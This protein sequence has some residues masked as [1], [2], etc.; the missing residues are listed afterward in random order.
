MLYLKPAEAAAIV[1]IDPA[2]IYRAIR[3]HHARLMSGDARQMSGKNLTPEGLRMLAGLQGWKID[4][5]AL[6]RHGSGDVRQSQAHQATPDDARQ[7]PDMLSFLQEQIQE[8]DG[9]IRGLL[10]SQAEERR[11]HDTLIQG[12]AKQIQNQAQAIEDMRT[13][14]AP[15]PTPAP[16]PAKVTPIRQEKPQEH[17]AKSW[18]AWKLA[19]VRFF[20]PELLRGSGLRVA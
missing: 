11:R 12:L 15:A 7:A 8:K 4:E 10:E 2:S 13:K 1:G 3:R 9:I 17:P 14:P 18:P 20:H 6:A 19:Y 16:K 5:E